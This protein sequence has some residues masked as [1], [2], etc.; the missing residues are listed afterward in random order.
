MPGHGLSALALPPLIVAVWLP[1]RWFWS[2]L[3]PERWLGI[4]A[5]APLLIVMGSLVVVPIGQRSGAP[6]GRANPAQWWWAVGHSWPVWLLATIGLQSS[7]V[8]LRRGWLVGYIG[9]AMVASLGA[10]AQWGRY[11]YAYPYG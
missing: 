2:R 9:L 5:Y 11:Y 8:V 10:V 4:A 1:A 6:L 7:S 3:F